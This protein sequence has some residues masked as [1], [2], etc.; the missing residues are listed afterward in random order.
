MGSFRGAKSDNVTPS[1]RIVLWQYLGELVPQAFQDA[2]FGDVDRVH[3]D[4]ELCGDVFGAES[5]NDIHLKGLA[6]GL[7]NSLFTR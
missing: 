6:V 2:G 7:L 1:I 4:A 3:G 5:I